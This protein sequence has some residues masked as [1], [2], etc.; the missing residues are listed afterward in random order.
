MMTIN[1][2]LFE[3]TPFLLLVLLFIPVLGVKSQTDTYALTPERLLP[4]FSTFSPEAASLGKY[5]AYN[6]SEYSG[7]PEIK[8]PLFVMESGDVSVPVEL[9][10]DAS[11]IKVEQDAT[12]VGLGWNLNYGGC[13][14]HVVCGND[15]FKEYPLNDAT[16]FKSYYANTNIPNDIPC[17]YYYTYSDYMSFVGYNGTMTL[18]DPTPDARPFKLHNDM[19]RGYYTPDV[20][21]ANFC[22]HHLSFIIDKRDSSKVV[23][24][25]DD[26]RKYRIEYEMGYIYPSVFRITNDKG[27]TYKFQA[28]S[29]FDNADAYYL[30]NI[31]G[32]DGISGRSSI[33][34]EYESL[35]FSPSNSRVDVKNANSFGRIIG[36]S[37]PND[38]ASQVT[39]LLG[40]YTSPV[41]L[42]S[43]SGIC[44][45][46]YPSR[47]ATAMDTVVFRLQA[48][49]D[50]TGAYAIDR[51]LVKSGN[52][53]TLDVINMSYGYF[54]EQSSPLPPSSATR[55]RLKLTSVTVNS[56]KYQMS[57]DSSLLPS[58][59]SYSKDYWGY[60]N[61]ADNG[62]NLCGTPKFTLAEDNVNTVDYLGVANR[63]ASEELC[64]AG[65]LERITYPT[66]GYTEFEFEA[67]R[68]TDH[69]YYPDASKSF[70]SNPTMVT[71]CILNVMGA[72]SQ[73]YDS[74]TF[75]LQKERRFRMEV[76]L[77]TTSATGDISTVTLKNTTTG[78]TI[79]SVS[80]TN[81]NTFS[82]TSD[83]ALAPGNYK[84]EARIT[85]NTS[86][87]STVAYCNLSH[88]EII[89]PASEISSGL[90][91]GGPSIG[92]GLRIKSIK[93]YDSGNIYL[94]GVEYEYTGG[95]LLSPTVRLEQ[96]FINFSYFPYD[97][98]TGYGAEQFTIFSFVY[99][100]SEP[101]YLYVCSLGIP[102]TVGYSSVIKK[103]VDES[104][105]VL[106][107]T[108][109]EYHNYG[110]E[111][112]VLIDNY[113]YYCTNGHLNGK[114]K[115]EKVSSGN[116][117]L[118]YQVAYS[119][120]SALQESVLFPKCLSGFLPGLFWRNVNFYMAF[121]RKNNYWTYLTRKTETRY[122]D[123][124]VQTTSKRT[125]YTYNLSNHQP[126]ILTVSDSLNTESTRYWY[127]SDNGNAS[128]G[129]AYLTSRHY[130]S[131]ITGIDVYRNNVYTAGSRYNYTLCNS[132]P[133][134]NT[135]YSI[136]PS[137]S[138]VLQMQVT[139]Y[140]GAG[141][142][143]EYYKKDGT[144][145]TIIWSYNHQYP[146]IEVIGKT[147][148][149]VLSVSASVVQL[150]N[151][152][153][154]SYSTI[155][156]LHNSL[157]QGLPDAHVTAYLYSPWHRVSRIIGPNGYETIYD[158]DND[159]RLVKEKDA[160]GTLKK[161]QYNYKIH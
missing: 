159:G 161:Y 127:P 95:K 122:D 109:L 74:Y 90:A 77:S 120:D 96:H 89:I 30:T 73:R 72:G 156:S 83:L 51:I 78:V 128:A 108:E 93:N 88:E 155:S 25:D 143:R 3:Q 160:S 100:N 2:R 18:C 116:N 152:S 114:L 67:N 16:Y 27:I 118:Q 104:G 123:L 103:E 26:S 138:A 68:F 38:L 59:A 39:A 13:I 64:K 70:I 79:D 17:Q 91:K 110:Y 42:T 11:G 32:A 40:S 139:D 56:K 10:Y 112:N 142:I 7:S 97:P 157:K 1:I 130:L 55:K 141:N 34:Y 23:V 65:M 94:N 41:F 12:F 134:A 126:S 153:S 63:Y 37:Y 20:F 71:D 46:V 21:Q 136:L 5:G 66:G 115:K 121:F 154:V 113:L 61:G 106:R 45:K 125:L 135:C 53:D 86:G 48:R 105:Q 149:E 148:D 58:F 146:V 145:V 44:H 111:S 24:L 19:S 22:G 81:G 98:G 85:V 87:N 8:I 60:Y 102:A 75:T 15:D 101:S 117:V 31:Y 131:E 140:D 151:D 57:Y 80:V 158:Y 50:L 36:G 137:G 52:N 33:T 29:E 6:V 144:P 35:A 92:G 4:H 47:I 14:N 124:G 62:Q 119:Y 69:Y 132:L 82:K 133:V 147:Y 28:F 76:G 84:L 43:P 9:Y 150:Q 129:L 107:K 99:A 54:D 49:A